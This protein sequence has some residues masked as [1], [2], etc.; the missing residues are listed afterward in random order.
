MP[1]HLLFHLLELAQG[2]DLPQDVAVRVETGEVYAQH[3]SVD[4]GHPGL[5]QQ[6]ML[7]AGKGRVAAAARLELRPLGLCLVVRD[8]GPVGQNVQR[9]GRQIHVLELH[10]GHPL[11]RI[12]PGDGAHAHQVLQ[13]YLHFPIHQYPSNT[14]RSLTCTVYPEPPTVCFAWVTMYFP[15][16]PPH[17]SS[18]TVTP[19][20]RSGL[21]GRVKLAV[22][23]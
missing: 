15:S 18:I 22:L 12:G 23:A 7:V 14:L 4:L 13:R 9:G 19:A 8:V 6:V 3:H 10:T 16:Q 5:D 1:R 17:F 11:E 20:T 2:P 21:P